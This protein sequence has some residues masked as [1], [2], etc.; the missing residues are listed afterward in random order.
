[1]DLIVEPPPWEQPPFPPDLFAGQVAL[2]TGGGSGMGLGMARVFAQ[3]GAAVAVVGRSVERANEGVRQLQVLGARAVAIMAARQRGAM[4]WLD[5]PAL[6]YGVI[7]AATVG[8]SCNL[9]QT[10][11]VEWARDGLRANAIVS[12]RV[13]DADAAQLRSLGQLAAYLCSDYAAYI[14]GCSVGID[15]LA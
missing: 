7:E 13:A 10:L 11:S 3:S 6:S 4:L 1:M 8:A 14:A 9:I 15:D 5:V 12:R 2:V